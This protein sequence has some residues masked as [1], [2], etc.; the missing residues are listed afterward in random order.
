MIH[1]NVGIYALIYNA[2]I[3]FIN[4]KTN[5]NKVEYSTSEILEVLGISVNDELCM[6][7]NNILLRGE[8]VRF[9]GML[10][11]N[12]ESDLNSVKEL[13]KKINYAWK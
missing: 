4:H 8:S 2:V 6:K 5:S 1:Q 10:S 9:A 13:L 7:I 12:A 3:C 11:S